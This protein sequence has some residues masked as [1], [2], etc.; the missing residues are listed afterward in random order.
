MQPDDVNAHAVVE[1]WLGTR[2]IV[3]HRPTPCHWPM[4]FGGT[5]PGCDSNLEFL[6]VYL[7]M[8]S[9]SR[10]VLNYKWLLDLKGWIITSGMTHNLARSFIVHIY[11]ILLDGAAMRD[12]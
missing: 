6:P 11:W 4:R 8:K 1:R 12:T 7:C 10:V 5:H 2:V 3:D 9:T